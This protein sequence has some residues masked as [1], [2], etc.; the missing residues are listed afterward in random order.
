ME[1]RLQSAVLPAQTL[2]RPK[3]LVVD[4][5]P[6]NLVAMRRLL[7]KIDAELVMVSSGNDALAACLDHEFALI[8]LDVQMPDIDGFEVAGLL[9]GEARTA[10]TPIIFVTA[11]F[12]DDVNRLRG[13]HFGAVDYIAKP[14]NDVILQS[15]VR[16]F[17]DLY[18]G[19]QE[20][21]MLVAELDGRNRQLEIEITERRRAEQEV[22][23]RATHDALTELPNRALFMDRVEQAL[24]RADR[25]RSHVGLLYLD[26][27]GFKPVNDKLGHH[28]GDVLLQQIAH[29]LRGAIRK[30][31]TVARLGG[32]EFAVV[33]EDAV[34]GPQA[35]QQ[36]GEK[37]LEVLAAP[38]ALDLGLAVPV[39]VNIGSSIGVAIFPDDCRGATDRREA[40]IRAADAAMYAAK[41]SGKNRVLLAS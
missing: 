36:L 5:T 30:S 27:D 11:A 10:D 39:P 3:I 13:Y 35:A 38:Y 21:Q 32:D 12:S 28:A 7:S 22:R 1:E 25:Q 4:D 29:R 41:Q 33:M 24:Q 31:D 6:A 40:L 18:R 16:V 23:H 14:I 15:K 37:L 26:I 17:L 9:S 34:E 2:P 19:R 20:L 8:L